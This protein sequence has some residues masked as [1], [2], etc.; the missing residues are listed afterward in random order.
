M[1]V[2]C[3]IAKVGHCEEI[4]TENAGFNAKVQR[5]L[6]LD[7]VTKQHR[8]LQKPSTSLQLSV[9]DMLTHVSFPTFVTADTRYGWL[10]EREREREREGWVIA[11]EL[12]MDWVGLGQGSSVFDGFGWVGSSIAKILG[13]RFER[14][15]LVHLKLS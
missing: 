9:S 12:S 5:N 3:A 7:F 2:V 6:G 11:S 13:Y 15:A 10:R 4:V 1:I 8:S 14:I